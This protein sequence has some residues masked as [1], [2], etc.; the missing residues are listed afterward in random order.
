MTDA[1]PSQR[2]PQPPADGREPPV[3]RTPDEALA[4][5][6]PGGPAGAQAR[7]FAWLFGGAG[8]CVLL[9]CGG[10]LSW[11][12]SWDKEDD[13]A[14]IREIAAGLFVAEVPERFKPRE[15]LGVPPPPVLGWFRDGRVDVIE[16]QTESGGR[17]NLTRRS[18]DDADADPATIVAQFAADTFEDDADAVR[19]VVARDGREFPVAVGVSPATPE[20][21]AGRPAD[22]G[23]VGMMTRVFGV[24]REGEATYLVQISLPESEYDDAEIT[25]FLRS[26]G[27]AEPAA[28]E[29]QPAAE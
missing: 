3:A 8:L 12:N 21:A 18:P 25:A 6:T 19:T 14:R 2:P 26:L 29:Q 1:S 9:C 15:A 5:A 10:G 20:E 7:I 27:P 28:E 24:F 13:P 22:G 23:S 11:V 17:L 16:Y 4:A